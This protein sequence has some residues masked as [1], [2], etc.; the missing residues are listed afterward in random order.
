MAK[1]ADFNNEGRTGFIF[2]CPGCKCAHFVYTDVLGKP[3]WT[4]NGSYDKPTF[5]P[6]ILT[7]KNDPRHTCHS[8]VTD[9]KIQFLDDCYHELKGQTV[10]LPDWED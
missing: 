8:Y 2:Q 3:Q 1:I 4:W 7:C 5:Q 6:S 9:G 10:E